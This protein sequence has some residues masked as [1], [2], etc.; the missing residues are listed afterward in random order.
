MEY[1][2][3]EDLLRQYGS[4]NILSIINAMANLS[5]NIPIEKNF[6]NCI[7]ALDKYYYYSND[8]NSY[9]YSVIRNNYGTNCLL[10]DTINLL[11]YQYKM[12]NKILDYR[13]R[14][15]YD[16]IMQQVINNKKQLY[17]YENT[18]LNKKSR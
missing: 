5:F 11:L 3:F 18:I 17:D 7:E 6:D 10:E 13:T 9:V 8:I 4:S 12:R 14:F 16:R 1:N 2:E 15:I